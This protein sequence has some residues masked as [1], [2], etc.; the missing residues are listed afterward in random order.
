VALGYFIGAGAGSGVAW[1]GRVGPSIGACSGAPGQVKHVDVCFCPCSNAC[2]LTKRAN[3][4][5]NP[6]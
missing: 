3:L 6:M 2:W 4:A 1:H 5:K